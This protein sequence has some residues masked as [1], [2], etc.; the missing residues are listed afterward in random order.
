MTTILILQ[1]PRGGGFCIKLKSNDA[2]MFKLCVETLKSFV[3]SPLRS[4]D[5]TSSQWVVVESATDRVHRWL[6][7]ASTNLHAQVEWLSSGGDDEPGEGWTPPPR[8]KPPKQSKEDEAFNAL[9][10]QNSAPPELIKAAYRVMALLHHP[11][12]GGDE[13]KMK[14]INA[15]YKQLSA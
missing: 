7:Y 13:A 3:P 2:G 11:D 14:A 12:K 10:L 15:A 5:P 6:G 4:Y 9:H 8:P 1:I